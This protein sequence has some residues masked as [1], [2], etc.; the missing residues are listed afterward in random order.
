MTMSPAKILKSPPLCAKHFIGDSGTTNEMD[1]GNTIRDEAT[2]RKLY[3]LPY[4]DA[5]KA[6]KVSS[7]ALANQRNHCF[8]LILA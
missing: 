8:H 2:M 7:S 5:I 4:C 3:P 1:H 6:D